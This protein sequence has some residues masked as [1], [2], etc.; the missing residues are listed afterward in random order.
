MPCRTRVT[1]PPSSICFQ[2]QGAILSIDWI[3]W[4]DCIHC[5]GLI[6]PNSWKCH[7]AGFQAQTCFGWATHWYES[8][9]CCCTKSS[10]CVS[11]YFVCVRQEYGHVGLLRCL[12]MMR[13]YC[14]PMTHNGSPHMWRRLESS[15]RSII[16]DFE[17]L[18]PAFEACLPQYYRPCAVVEFTQGKLD[19]PLVCY[20]VAQTRLHSLD[21]LALNVNNRRML[22]QYYERLNNC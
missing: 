22:D 3:D 2:I 19:A 21:C 13:L 16:E 9:N 6:C 17:V 8:S 4:I 10:W 1:Q 12:E 20:L 18:H 7:R 5:P 14:P 15:V 11:S